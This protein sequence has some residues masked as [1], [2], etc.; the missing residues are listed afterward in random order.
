MHC[1]N[2]LYCECYAFIAAMASQ[3]QSFFDKVNSDA[4]LTAKA[5]AVGFSDFPKIVDFAKELGFTITTKELEDHFKEA[6]GDASDLSEADLSG[7]AGGTATALAA[8]VV[9]AGAGVTS[10][11][12]GSGW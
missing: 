1:A 4:A 10:T 6:L 9:G 8:A 11:T 2:A 5:K 12:Q 3:V 7:V